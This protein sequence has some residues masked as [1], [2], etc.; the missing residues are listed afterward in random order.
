MAVAH[1]WYHLG[2]RVSDATHEM[3]YRG[4]R[5]R[6]AYY[7]GEL[8]WGDEFLGILLDHLP[9]QLH[10]ERRE[11]VNYN[12]VVILGVWSKGRTEDITDK[13]EFHPKEGTLIDPSTVLTGIMVAQLP[14]KTSYSSGE[15]LTYSGVRVV[16]VYADGHMANVTPECEFSPKEGTIANA[17]SLIGI[18]VTKLPT[19]STYASGDELDLEGVIVV[20]VYTNGVTIDVTSECSFSPDDGHTV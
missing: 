13:C 11:A 1:I 9:Y 3:Y 19:K 6:E 2:E 7:R 5:I 15:R 12:G 14:S 18:F 20:A 17:P 8:I 4:Q 10:Y 16:A